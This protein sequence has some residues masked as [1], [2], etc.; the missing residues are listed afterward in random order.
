[1]ANECLR[2]P[3][4][5]DAVV[6]ARWPDR[7]DAELAAH[8]QTCEVCRDLATVV[9]AMRRDHDDVWKEANVPSSGQVWWRAELR[10]RHEAIRAASQPITVAQSVAATLVLGVALLFGLWGWGTVLQSVQVLWTTWYVP[11][12]VGL[13]ALVLLVTPILYLVLSDE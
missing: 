13:G 9:Q 1:M 8:V 11:L 7:V 2:E 6:S 5:I 4:V 12:L 3:D 10:A